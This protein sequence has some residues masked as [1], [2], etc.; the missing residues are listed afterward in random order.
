MTS[1]CSLGNAR[2]SW[3][4][5][6]A[7]IVV[8]LLGSAALVNYLRTRSSKP[9][10]SSLLPDMPTKPKP[11]L[12]SF[13][14]CPPEGDGGDADLNRLKNRVDEGQ[15]F[16]L[17]FDAVEQLEW[18]KTIER[19]RRADW[20]ASDLATVGV[21]AVITLD[22]AGACKDARLGLAGVG[23]TPIRAKRAEEVLKG[24][25][26][27]DDLLVEAGEKAS[28]MSNPSSDIR[29][30]AEYKREMVKVYVERAIR[31]SLTRI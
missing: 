20:S 29:G 14:G 31:L 22:K 28:E 10:T 27:S 5:I 4:V 26:L 24:Q 6:S 2:A 18:P 17:P 11:L 12:R 7:L 8:T 21:A 25:K 1:K 9:A 3:L 19:R 16:S 23:P 30:S 15:Y 13:N